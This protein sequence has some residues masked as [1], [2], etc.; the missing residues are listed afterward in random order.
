MSFLTVDLD[1][2]GMRLVYDYFG[3]DKE[4]RDCLM[5]IDSYE[6]NSPIKYLLPHVP[7]ADSIYEFF[8]K[9][10]NGKLDI[11]YKSLPIPETNDG[12]VTQ[13]VGLNFETSVIENKNNVFL[14]VFTTYCPVCINIEPVFKKL[15]VD[16][17]NKENLVFAEF[18]AN[19]NEHKLISVESF[20]QF[21]FYRNGDKDDPILYNG[22]LTYDALKEF[23][24]ATVNG[25]ES[26]PLGD[27]E[28]RETDT[29]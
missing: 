23:L 5:M 10:K 3:F 13:V 6:E 4:Q 17:A 12:P 27:D 7:T 1:D 22:E 8:E 2:P 11:Y 29:L 20:P 26:Q 16:F 24:E 18:N 15:A 25:S 28:T 9:H 21:Y 19:D 14:K